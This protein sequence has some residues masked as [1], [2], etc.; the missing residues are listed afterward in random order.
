MIS[1]RDK[2]C[3]TN[4][5]SHHWLEVGVEHGEVVHALGDVDALLLLALPIRAGHLDQNN[6]F[7]QIHIS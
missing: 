3:F 4:V 7:T 2:L 1:F 6:L 5:C